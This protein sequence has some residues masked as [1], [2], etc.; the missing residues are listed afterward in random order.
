M[1]CAEELMPPTDI[2]MALAVILGISAAIALFGARLARRI[3][4]R[5]SLLLALLAAGVL[6]LYAVWFIDDVA[7]ARVLPFTNVIIYG[8]P[9]GPAMGLLAGLATVRMPGRAARRAVLVVPLVMIGLWRVVSPIVGRPPSI[10]PDRWTNGVCRQ[11]SKSSCSAASAATVL[12]ACGIMTNERE[13]VRE[14]LTHEEGTA[15]LGL[16]RGMTVKTRGTAWEIV[17]FSGDADSLAHAPLPAI[18]SIGVQGLYHYWLG[19]ANHSVVLFTIDNHGNADIGDP[20]VGRQRWTRE[21][22]RAV[23]AREGIGV[24]RR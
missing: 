2:L 13:M 9:Q 6:V 15:T 8:N 5:W 22:L 23:Y 17:P 21:Q 24:R 4:P 11:S 12:A 3:A 1:R 18:I 19:G 16:F 20:F 10:G 14:C 7:L